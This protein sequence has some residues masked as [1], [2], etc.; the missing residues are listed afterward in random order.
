MFFAKKL[1][2]Y[3]NILGKNIHINA[4][5][6]IKK[7]PLVILILYITIIRLSR[8]FFKKT[9]QKNDLTRLSR[10]YIYADILTTFN[11]TNPPG[12]LIDA[13]SP[14]FLPINPAPTGLILLII[15]CNG[16]DSVSPTILY[17]KLRPSLM[18]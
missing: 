1:Y 9:Y 18:F 14:T 13:T 12:V 11:S 6:N 8:C 17:V 7:V 16:S 15:P 10:F 5:Y 3:P 4:T 2:I